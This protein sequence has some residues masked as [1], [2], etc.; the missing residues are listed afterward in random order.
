MVVCWC[1]P[2]PLDLLVFFGVWQCWIIAGAFLVPPSSGSPLCPDFRDGPGGIG[3]AGQCLRLVRL[4][5]RFSATPA[6]ILVSTV[7]VL[8]FSFHYLGPVVHLLM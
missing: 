5:G 4:M 1:A 3:V 6:W 8:C 2:V 7:H